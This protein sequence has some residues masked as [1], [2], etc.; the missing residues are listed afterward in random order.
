MGNQAGDWKLCF[1]KPNGAAIILP[2]I[3]SLWNLWCHEATLLSF[4]ISPSLWNF[5]IIVNLSWCVPLSQPNTS[6]PHCS[7][8]ILLTDTQVAECLTAHSSFGPCFII[9]I[10]IHFI[11]LFRI[12]TALSK[13]DRLQNSRPQWLTDFGR[14]I[15]KTL[16]YTDAPD[17]DV[18]WVAST[19]LFRGNYFRNQ[20]KL[21]RD[22]YC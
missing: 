19:C 13:T 10:Y 11:C 12:N 8:V 6:L 5:E 22:H 9:L 2:I 14:Q 16:L 18:I 4:V 21:K 7:W 20:R 3:L 1:R 17:T 15:R